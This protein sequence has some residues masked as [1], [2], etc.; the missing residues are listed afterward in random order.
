M[1]RKNTTTYTTK[2]DTRQSRKLP[3]HP[4]VKTGRLYRRGPLADWQQSRWKCSPS[5]CDRPK[6]LAVLYE[7]VRRACECEF[8]QSDRNGES[9]RARA[10]C[11]SEKDIY[12]ATASE[13]ARGYWC[14][15][16]VGECLKKQKGS[17]L[18]G[19][20]N[21]PLQVLVLRMPS[22][23]WAHPELKITIN[24]WRWFARKARMR[25]IRRLQYIS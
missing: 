7:P 23:P 25:L 20:A 3:S 19:N 1:A 5:L 9:E 22:M 4:M 8:I 24:T 21:H 6:K 2:I 15:A 11:L 14:I 17:H 13:K 16:A 12:L 10:L 18:R